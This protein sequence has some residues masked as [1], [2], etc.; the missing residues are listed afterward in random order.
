MPARRPRSVASGLAALLLLAACTPGS[1][2]RSPRSS[3]APATVTPTAPSL[4]ADGRPLTPVPDVVPAGVADPPP[5]S[6]IERY[7]SQ[8]LSWRPCGRGLQCTTVRAPLDHDDPDGGALTLALARRPATAE[9][10]RGTLFI[11]PGGPGAS[12]RSYVGYF[13]AEGLESYDVVGWDPRGV[14]A[15]TPVRCYGAGDLDRYLAVDVSP[16]DEAEEQA[17]VAETYA[18]GQA[19]LQHSGALLEHVSTQATVRDLDLLRRLVGDPELHYFG[20]SYGTEIG[21]LYAQLYPEV[22]GRVVLDGAVDIGGSDVSQLEGFERALGHFARWAATPG[23]GQ[24]LGSSQAAV[25]SRIRRLLAGLD[26]RPLTT[27]GGRVLSQQQGVQALVNP[28]YGR[29]QW[30]DLLRA[31]VAGAGGDGRELLALADQGNQ[32]DADGTYGQINDAFPAVRCL[33]SRE[34]SIA[35]AEEEAAEE[36]ARAPVL[37]AFAGAD[38]VCPLW[39]VA[40]APKAPRITAA[41]AGPIVVLGTTGDPATPYENAVAMADQLRSGVLVTLEGEGHTAYDQ[42]SCVRGLVLPYLRGGPPPPDRSRCA[43]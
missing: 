33:D 20:A 5:G 31:L 7:R 8:T 34:T 22:V 17:L 6:G 38:L 29:E 39:P 28:L 9:P 2:D 1:A 40:P 4:P 23:A 26:Q 10:R 19:C 24:P 16:D 42:S 25:L 27:P 18:F 11:N 15:S 21:A 37:G 41:G 43:G 35:R 3:P 12:G 13:D 36:A 32:R 30:P 14:G